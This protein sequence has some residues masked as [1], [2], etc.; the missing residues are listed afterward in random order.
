MIKRIEKL[1][2]G[3]LFLGI[4]ILAYLILKSSIDGFGIS[5]KNNTDY[6]VT[7]QFGDFVGGVIGTFFALA[8]TLLIYLSFREQTN[9]NKRNAFESS[10]F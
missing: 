7:G 1:A 4:I 9:E 3:F 2:W 8:G 5:L 6:T 10:F